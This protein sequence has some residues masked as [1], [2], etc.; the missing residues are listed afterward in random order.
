MVE[1]APAAIEA[2]EEEI[3]LA[4]VERDPNDDKN[5][6]VEIRA[7]PAATRPRS[8]PATCTACTPATPNGGVQGRADVAVESARGRRLQGGRLR[9]QGRWGLLEDEVRGRHA[10]GAAGPGDRVTGPH[11]HLDR[12]G[13]RTAGGRG[14]RDRD[15]AEGTARSTSTAPAAPAASRSTRPTRRCG[16]RTCRAASWSDA[17]PEV[18]AAEPRAAMRVLR[19][20]LTSA[21]WRAAGRARRRAPRADRQRR[22]LREDPHLQLPAGPRYRPPDRADRRTISKACSAAD[23]EEFT[24]ALAAEEKRQ[25]LET[26]AVG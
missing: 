25:R 23:C 15:Q 2:L 11:P 4:M 5:V 13:G 26:A 19:A 10:S 6:I 22:A 20:R 1:E 7:G 24:D 9:D 3:R 18:A 21:N 8:S 16:S 17:G 12:D 14:S